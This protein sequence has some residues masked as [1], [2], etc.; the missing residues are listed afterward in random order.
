MNFKFLQ[1]ALV[2]DKQREEFAEVKHIREPVLSLIETMKD[3]HQWKFEKSTNHDIF[4]KFYWLTH[5][6][7]GVK[8]GF[9]ETTKAYITTSNTPY[10]LK[11]FYGLQWAT[12]PEKQA[13]VEAYMQFKIEHTKIDDEYT[14]MEHQAERERF[15]DIFVKD[16]K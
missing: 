10:Q 7:S 3:I 15:M 4:L 1:K 11:I 9:S 8:L 6:S 5:I 2:A 14:A 13:V 16:K 12:S